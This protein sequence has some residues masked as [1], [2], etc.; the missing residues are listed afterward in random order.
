V[1]DGT[2]ADTVLLTLTD[3]TVGNTTLVFEIDFQ[4]KLYVSVGAS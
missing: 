2:E 4:D 1:T 3:T